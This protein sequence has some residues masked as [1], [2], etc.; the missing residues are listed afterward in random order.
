MIDRKYF[1]DVDMNRDGFVTKEET[2]E[3]VKKW[4]YKNEDWQEQFSFFDENK[5]GKL[6]PEEYH[7]RFQKHREL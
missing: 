5:N 1:D 6:T 7:D 2:V 3:F 4:E